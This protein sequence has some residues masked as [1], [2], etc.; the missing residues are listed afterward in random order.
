M[1]VL[2]VGFKGANIFFNDYVDH[3]HKLNSRKIGLKMKLVREANDMSITELDMRLNF[4]WK[5]FAL[6]E[7]GERLSSLEY[8]YNFCK[9]FDYS[10]E[11]MLS[12]R[13]R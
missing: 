5:T 11:K 10:F 2:Y 9:I 4:N 6:L 7:D 3:Y 1:K 8:I 13:R 12:W